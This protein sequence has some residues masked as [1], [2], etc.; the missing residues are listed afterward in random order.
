M[1]VAA[2]RAMESQVDQ[3]ASRQPKESFL[4]HTGRTSVLTTV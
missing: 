1:A 2:W 3:R 4:L